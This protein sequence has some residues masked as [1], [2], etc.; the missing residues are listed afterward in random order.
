MYNILSYYDNIMN[1]EN[2][3]KS[4]SINPFKLI[5]IQ[6]EIYGTESA[7]LSEEDNLLIKNFI[8]TVKNKDVLSNESNEKILS[9]AKLF[10]SDHAHD[11]Y[12]AC[13]TKTIPGTHS[14]K[15]LF[16]ILKLFFPEDERFKMPAE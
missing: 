11:L 14:L 2:F 4:E 5:E 10:Y 3:P 8:G 16:Q 1:R 12:K 15:N 13:K 9:L 7:E 6:A